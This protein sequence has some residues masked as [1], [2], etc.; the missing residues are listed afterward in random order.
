[1]DTNRSGLLEPEEIPERARGFITRAAG[2]ASLDMAA[3]LPIDKLEQALRQMFRRADGPS[4]GPPSPSSPAPSPS[5]PA[6][7]SPAGASPPSSDAAQDAEPLVKGF[8]VVVNL[9]PVP[10]FGVRVGTSKT[11]TAGKSPA[12][13]QAAD[14]VRRFDTDG[15]GILHKEEW[16]AVENE[17]GWKGGGGHRKADFN[18]DDFISR[19]ELAAFI[20]L[21][22]PANPT[23]G[24]PGGPPGG[25]GRPGPGGPMRGP[26]G[27]QP[28]NSA[29]GARPWT[30]GSTAQT[31]GADTATETRR[32]YRFLTPAERLPEGLPEWFLPKDRNLD[33]QVAMS[34][35]ETDW[36]EDRLAEYGRHDLNQD[37]VITPAECLKALGVPKLAAAKPVPTPA[38]AGGPPRGPGGPPPRGPGGPPPRGPGNPVSGTHDASAL[39]ARYDGNADGRLDKDEWKQMEH[40]EGLKGGGGHKKADQDYDERITADE[41]AAWLAT[42]VA[43]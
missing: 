8:D 32:S 20:S 26:P 35:F 36:T 5:S 19:E 2:V 14:V 43:P 28:L 1:L 31:S 34:E 25:P 27:T 38:P 3:P 42:R 23:G 6:A 13:S 39:V 37:G 33:G 4:Q 12:E 11:S 15:D 22:D 24:G 9:T 40:A 30:T 18:L 29:S 21:Q 17:M 41:L 10:G 16:K 7:Q